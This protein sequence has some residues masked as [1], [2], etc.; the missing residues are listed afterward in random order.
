MQTGMS[1]ESRELV[2]KK[3]EMVFVDT[4]V[5]YL[6]TQNAHWNYVGKDFFSVHQ[7]LEAQYKDM[8]EAV[9]ELAERVRALDFF[10]TVSLSFFQKKSNILFTE[11]PTSSEI[12]KDLVSGQEIWISQAR[13][14]CELAEQ[15]K[16]A[17]TV[18]LLGK[19]LATHEKFLWMLKNY[20]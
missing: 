11:T 4:Y 16:D 6:K 10:V 5:L 12:I 7:L 9:D 3:L 14:I 20:L 1:K 15:E 2:A 13:K 19:R 18:D 8:A 17:G